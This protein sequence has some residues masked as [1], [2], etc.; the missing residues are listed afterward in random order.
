M[1]RNPLIIFALATALLTIN[2]GS[3]QPKPTTSATLAS[4]PSPSITEPQV[5]KLIQE[6]IEKGGAIRERVQADVNQ[7]FGWTIGLLQALTGVLA[8]LPIFSAI[9]LWC[10]RTGIKKQL[11]DEIR[12]EVKDEVAQQIQIRIKEELQVKF[13]TLQ[14]EV[15]A[16]GQ[17]IQKLYDDFER[18][19]QRRLADLPE[20]ILNGEPTEILP[21]QQ[22]ALSEIE[23]LRSLL[24]DLQLSAE[25]YFKLGNALYNE[26][27]FEEAI[28]NYDKA[29]ELNPDYYQAWYNHGYILD[30]VGRQEE[31]IAS[32]DKSIESKPDFQEAWHNRGLLLDNL[33][34]HEEALKSHDMALKLKP[35]DYETFYNRGISLH[36]LE[37]YEQEIASYDKAIE[38]KPDYA[39]AWFN[40][41]CVYGFKGDADQT[42]E[43]LAKAIELDPKNR[44]NAKNE[45]DFDLVRNDE[46][47]KQLLEE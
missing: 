4:V 36:K 13:D 47:F 7:T 33:G 12:K 3:A 28:A 37:R 1:K 44:E 30:E 43:N 20:S 16:T 21:R 8:A 27:R 31:A 26:G 46:R 5:K 34:H 19:V 25:G 18:E 23:I 17:K 35:D 10:L 2:V 29:L 40:K 38:L 9:L 39:N 22:Q 41:A 42:I 11:V 32:Y 6:E 24:P 15:D 14:K 45:S